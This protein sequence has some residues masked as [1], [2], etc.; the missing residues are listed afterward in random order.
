MVNIN[1]GVKNR[2]LIMMLLTFNFSA[3]A[4][5]LDGFL[6]FAQRSGS[7]T[8]INAGGVIEDQRSG[9]LTGGSIISRGPLG[10]WNCNPSAYSY[11]VPLWTVAR[12]H[13]M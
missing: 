10:L 12:D 8:S 4:G 7:M 13:T 9:F 3:N 11:P 5:G 2:I 6:K 1:S